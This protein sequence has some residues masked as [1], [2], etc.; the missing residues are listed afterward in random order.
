MLTPN[1]AHEISEMTVEVAR[2]AFPKGNVVMRIRD[3][4]GP[5]FEDNEFAAL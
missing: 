3:E 1:Y 4:L 2:A 5:L